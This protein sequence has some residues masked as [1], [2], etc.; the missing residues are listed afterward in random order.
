MRVLHF[1]PGLLQVVHEAEDDGAALSLACS[2]VRTHAGARAVAVVSVCDGRVVAQDGWPHRQ[3]AP[4]EMADLCRE[5][6]HVDREPGEGAGMVQVAAPVRYGGAIIGHVVGRGGGGDTAAVEDAVQAFAALCGPALRARLDLRDPPDDPSALMPEL[7]GR[8][9]SMMAVRE[10]IRQAARTGFSVLIEGESGTGKELVARALHRLSDRRARRFMA[11]NCAALTDD[12]V[13]AELFGFARG[14]F[15]GAVTA[16]AGLFEDASGGSLFLDEVSE[17]SVR[18][19]AKLLRALQEREVRRVGENAARTIDVRVIAATNQP[20]AEAAHVGRFRED[21]LFRLAVVRIVLPPLR[22]RPEDLPSLAAAFWRRALVDVGKQVRLT[23]DAMAALCGHG[24][25]GNVRELQN[26]MAGLAVR[27]PVRGRLGAR[28][29]RL[30]LSGGPPAE[31][32]GRSLD[33]L[34]RQCER[35]AVAGALARHGG[36]RSAAARELGLS[37]QGLSKAI[38]RLGLDTTG[39]VSGVA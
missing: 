14:A 17:L 35:R 19:Q 28:E 23:R 38:R 31:A 37:R 1:V 33:D 24:W 9:P 5:V 11:V 29:V 26:V 34:R 36:R 18:A 20:L 27:A 3:L 7:M 22:E 32:G 21:L 25:P 8:S 30:H 4:G 16:R 39:E 15:T 10:S 2:W 12:L 13:E 6:P